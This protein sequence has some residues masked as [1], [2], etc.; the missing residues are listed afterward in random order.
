MYQ[1]SFVFN[2][3]IFLLLF[4]PTSSFKNKTLFNETT[5]LNI[6]SLKEKIKNYEKEYMD[7]FIKSS[8]NEELFC[9][10][11]KTNIKLLEE[12]KTRYVLIENDVDKGMIKDMDFKEFLDVRGDISFGIRNVEI[13]IKKLKRKEKNCINNDEEFLIVKKE[14]KEK[15]SKNKEKMIKNINHILKLNNDL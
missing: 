15:S 6:S 12:I 13:I 9:H 11:I 1:I 7:L 14:L 5:P 2:S 3:F 8:K 10:K 4:V